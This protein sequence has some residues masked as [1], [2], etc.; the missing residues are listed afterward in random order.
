MPEAVVI[1]SSVLFLVRVALELFTLEKD[2]YIS[3]F[4]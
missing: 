4:V 1:E 2:I 3:P